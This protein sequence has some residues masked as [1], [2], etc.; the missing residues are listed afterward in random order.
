MATLICHCFL[1]LWM[2]LRPTAASPMSRQASQATLREQRVHGC[3]PSENELTKVS[4]NDVPIWK[5]YDQ[6]VNSLFNPPTL[7]KVCTALCSLNLWLVQCARHDQ[8]KSKSVRR[9]RKTV[10]MIMKW[11]RAWLQSLNLDHHIAAMAMESVHWGYCNI[12]AGAYNGHFAGDA[13]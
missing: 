13:A 11:T 2:F 5:A 10:E 7:K 8:C 9:R 1:Q 3:N 6:W 12:L 4:K